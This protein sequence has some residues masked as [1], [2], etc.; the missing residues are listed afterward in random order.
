MLPVAN[1]TQ[2]LLRRLKRPCEDIAL[3]SQTVLVSSNGEA[4]ERDANIV[5]W[6]LLGILRTRV[7][8]CRQPC[9][10]AELRRIGIQARFGGGEGV[11]VADRSDQLEAALAHELRGLLLILLVLRYVPAL[12]VDTGYGRRCTVVASCHA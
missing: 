9:F 5:S 10:R 7:Q 1:Q 8:Q 6:I 2:N 4:A 12:S 3:V 11:F